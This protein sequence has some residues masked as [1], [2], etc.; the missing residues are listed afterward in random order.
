MSIGVRTTWI[1]NDR[2][3]HAAISGENA[4]ADGRFYSGIM[5]PEATFDR[6][7]T[8]AGKYAYFCLL[9]PNMVGIVSVS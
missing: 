7:F 5:A 4:I 3:P 9:Y 1:N 6:S 8:E 2:V